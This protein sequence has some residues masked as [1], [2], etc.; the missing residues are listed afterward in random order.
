MKSSHECVHEGC[1]EPTGGHR[2]CIKH[3]REI[4]EKKLAEMKEEQKRRQERCRLSDRQ[5]KLECE[6]YWTW[7]NGLSKDERKQVRKQER[8]KLLEKLVK[9]NKTKDFEFKIKT[10][11]PAPFPSG[12]P[13]NP[14]KKTSS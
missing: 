2:Y 10:G 12:Q 11:H 5:F 8:K 6:K 14:W 9:D 3:R 7:I 1:D 4:E 13:E